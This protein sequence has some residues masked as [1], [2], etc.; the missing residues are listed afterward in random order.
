MNLCR[1]CYKRREMK[2]SQK[3][4]TYLLCRLFLMIVLVS[5]ALSNSEIG[6]VFSVHAETMTNEASANSDI[7]SVNLTITK[8]GNG[9]GTI[10]SDPAGI[11]CGLTCTFD[12][13][14][15]IVV[16]LTASA[17]TGSTFTGWS[18]GGC[19]GTGTCIV[20]MTAATAVT[21]NFDL[22]IL[23]L[24]VS[25]TGTGSGTVTSSPVGI[26]CGLD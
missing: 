20:T 17:N 6:G 21:A 23:T 4:V 9:S 16:T 25:R 11:D 2:M 13:A 5:W 3:P 7:T 10:T 19:T 22:Q 8:S 12:F 1:I 15:D 24:T 26:D 14:P 18:G